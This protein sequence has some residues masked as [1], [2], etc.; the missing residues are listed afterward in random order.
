MS[1]NKILIKFKFRTRNIFEK[2]VSNFFWKSTIVAQNV[3]EKKNNL[4]NLS[5]TAQD[6][7]EGPYKIHL[8]NLVF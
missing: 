5:F 8:K 2:Y 4:K 1:L 3:F 6:V 7:F